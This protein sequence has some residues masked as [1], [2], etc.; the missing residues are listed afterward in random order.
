MQ[1][2]TL[3]VYW[4]ARAAQPMSTFV[5]AHDLVTYTC[6]H[7]ASMQAAALALCWPAYAAQLMSMDD[8]STYLHHMMPGCYNRSPI[9]S[10]NHGLKFQNI[11]LMPASLDSQCLSFRTE[12]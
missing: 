2:A 5:D 7:H 10:Q 11:S 4:P 6:W 8:L 3:T 12:P 9:L 1:A